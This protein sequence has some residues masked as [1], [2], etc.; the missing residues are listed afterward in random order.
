MLNRAPTP[1]LATGLMILAALGPV[2][3]SCSPSAPAA[4]TWPG[5]LCEV[6]VPPAPAPA[7][8]SAAAPMRVPTSRVTVDVRVGAGSIL[9][10]LERAAPRRVVE[11]RGVGMGV[12]GRLSFAVDRG[13]FQLGLERDDLVVGVELV[14]D[15]ELCK[16]L[17]LFGCVPYASCRPAAHAHA[18]VSL[19]LDPAY[20][21][22][23]SRVDIPITRRCTL[24]ALDIDVTG[25]VQSEANRQA[26]SIRKQIDGGLPSLALP[27]A[28]LWKS[29]GT[30]VPVGLG[31]CARV[32]PTAV[33]Q[34][35]PRVREGLITLGVGAEGEVLVE[36]PCRPALPS[37]P[38]PPPRLDRTAEPGVDL[39]VPLVLSW[40]EVGRAVARSLALAEPVAGRE[41][42]HVTDVRAE[43]AATEEARARGGVRLLLS[44]AGRVCGELALDATVGAAPS[45]DALLLLGVAPSA[46]EQ[47]RAAAPGLDLA[48]L[49]AVIERL[50]RIGLPVEVPAIPRNIDRI[51]AALLGP[52]GGA[53]SGSE[54]LTSEINVSMRSASVEHVSSSREGLAAI[55]HAVGEATVKVRS[56]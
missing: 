49:A 26:D 12:A 42:L 36:S 10:Q 54:R 45:G 24:T 29:L 20:G 50:V 2:G 53:G 37:P 18:A 7:G 51:A 11:R 39:M 1:R 23:P 3:L 35:G 47:A 46:G 52:Q 22:P 8:G 27:I 15:A 9:E 31:A 30:S 13:A 32:Y 6:R 33:V 25:E 28:S 16:P 17:G 44:V 4:P 40:V 56:R 5:A 14:G 48:E 34:S 19:M 38:L 55:V 43:P 21:L 41:V